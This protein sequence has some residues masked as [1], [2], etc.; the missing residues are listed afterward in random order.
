ME[1]KILNITILV[2]LAVPGFL[3]IQACSDTKNHNLEEKEYRTVFYSDAVVSMKGDSI[4]G[5]VSANPDSH[6]ISVIK[7]DRYLKER[8]RKMWLVLSLFLLTVFATAI[9][10]YSSLKRR[11]IKQLNSDLS[12]KNE[13]ICLMSDQLESLGK[14]TDAI[15]QSL[16]IILKQN[17]ETIKELTEKRKLLEKKE[18]TDFYPDKLEALQGKI[19]SISLSLDR[20]HNKVPIQ[21]NLERTLDETKN[22]IMRIIRSIFGNSLNES[23]YQVLSGIFAGLSANEISFLTGLAPGTVRTR[24]SR[25]KT[26]IQALPNSQDKEAILSFFE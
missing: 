18:E 1:G 20:L 25:L 9:Y 4:I 7:D 19:D 21:T 22:G 3:A 17:I 6:I 11:I 13:T 24:K 2:M 14:K 26:R 15:S 5:T 16:N 12:Q 10:V 23:D 8:E